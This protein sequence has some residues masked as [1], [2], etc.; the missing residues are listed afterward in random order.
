MFV[1]QIVEQLRL[2]GFTHFE[3]YSQQNSDQTN[4]LLT[5]SSY[6]DK[7]TFNIMEI[8]FNAGH[9]AEIFL[10]HHNVI[11]TSFIYV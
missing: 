8:G 10:S 6:P 1:S 4:D 5:L 7:E 11:L 9:S 3:G 2:H